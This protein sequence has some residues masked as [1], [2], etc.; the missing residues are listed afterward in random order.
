MSLYLRSWIVWTPR[1]SSKAQG[2]SVNFLLSTQLWYREDYLTLHW[3]NSSTG[4][5]YIFR[6]SYEYSYDPSQMISYFIDKVNLI[7]TSKCS[8]FFS[9]F[10]ECKMWSNWTLLNVKSFHITEARIMSIL[11]SFLASCEMSRNPPQSSSQKTAFPSLYQ[12]LPFYRY[13]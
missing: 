7:S 4:L 12:L 2:T 6:M 13:W 1:W 8:V 9:L 3:Y 11:C 5:S 10:A